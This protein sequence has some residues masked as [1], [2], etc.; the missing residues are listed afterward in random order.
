M[1]V[2]NVFLCYNLYTAAE[3]TGGISVQALLALRRIKKVNGVLRARIAYHNERYVERVEERLAYH[4]GGEDRLA[5][6]ETCISTCVETFEEL[7]GQYRSLYALGD[8]CRA[9]ESELEDYSEITYC[10]DKDENGASFLRQEESCHISIR[11]FLDEHFAYVRA[12]YGDGI[13]TF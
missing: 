6:L 9:V 8:I 4:A 7:V 10:A 13:L 1:L 2:G 11:D 5:D 12:L 3:S